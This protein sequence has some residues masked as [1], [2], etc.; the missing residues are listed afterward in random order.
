MLDLPRAACTWQE[1]VFVKTSDFPTWH[2]MVLS[3]WLHFISFYVPFHLIENRKCWLAGT[4]VWPVWNFVSLYLYLYPY[5]CIHWI[6]FSHFSPNE[7][8]RLRTPTYLS[9]LAVSGSASSMFAPARSP[10]ESHCSWSKR[11]WVFR[12]FLAVVKRNSK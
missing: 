8:K 3:I 11:T 9:N 6:L 7:N 2:S 4:S 12:N 10:R 1:F 5:I